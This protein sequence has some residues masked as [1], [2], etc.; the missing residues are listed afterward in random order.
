[1]IN[2]NTMKEKQNMTHEWIWSILCVCV[3]LCSWGLI[4]QITLGIDLAEQS[5]SIVYL[6]LLSALPCLALFYFYKNKLYTSYDQEGI[7]INYFP[8][9][10]KVIRWREIKR[11]ELVEMDLFTYS[12]WR[13]EEY[14]MVY[15]AKG[16]TVLKLETASERLLIGTSLPEEVNHMVKTYYNMHT[17]KV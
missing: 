9:K 12:V 6:C 4:R 2:R 3:A 1:M 17:H 11:I 15:H 10:S 16:N 7:R 13:S 14:G 8:F 5:I